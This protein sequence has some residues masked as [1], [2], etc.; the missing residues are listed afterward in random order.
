MNSSFGGGGVGVHQSRADRLVAFLEQKK[1][2]LTENF[3]TK[4]LAEN[5]RALK[6]FAVTY[7]IL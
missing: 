2:V 4:K 6:V 3:H 7:Q 5:Y 1:K